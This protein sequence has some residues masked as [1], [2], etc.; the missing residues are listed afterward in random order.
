LSGVEL[1][2]SPEPSPEERQ[3]LLQALAALLV[4]DP[5]PAAYRSAWRELGLRENVEDAEEDL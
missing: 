5:R 3:A 1:E 2:I 4:R